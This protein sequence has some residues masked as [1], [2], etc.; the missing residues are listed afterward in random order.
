[1][2]WFEL[3]VSVSLSIGASVAILFL[4]S[5]KMRGVQEWARDLV[6]DVKNQA[7]LDGDKAYD[8]LRAANAR[9]V[10]AQNEL[11]EVRLQLDE[12]VRQRDGLLQALH[13]VAVAT[14]KTYDAAVRAA[15]PQGGGE[16]GS[17]TSPA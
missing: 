13:I 1:M 16:Q 10:S 12:A 5:H 7:D 14:N 2:T 15:R 8:A 9:A 4:L 17:G 11:A 6:V 3:L